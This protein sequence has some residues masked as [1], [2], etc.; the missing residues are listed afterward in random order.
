M[1]TILIFLQTDFIFYSDLT[2]IFTT[3]LLAFQ[4]F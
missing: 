2:V 4:S 3:T 1:N